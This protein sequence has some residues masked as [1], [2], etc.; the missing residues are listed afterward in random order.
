MHSVIVKVRAESTVEEI[1]T[2]SVSV[3]TYEGNLKSKLRY[4]FKIK[5]T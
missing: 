1:K 4:I 2:I 5:Q 3:T